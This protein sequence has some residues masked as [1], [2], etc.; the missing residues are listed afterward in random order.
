MIRGE[1]HGAALWYALPRS[2]R[3][4]LQVAFRVSLLDLLARTD[5]RLLETIPTGLVSRVVETLFRAFVAGYDELTSD[6]ET[7]D[8]ED[9]IAS[10]LLVRDGIEEQRNS[11][12]WAAAENRL[13]RELMDGFSLSDGCIDWEKLVRFVVENQQ[14]DKRGQNC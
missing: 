13:A 2:L 8:A 9:E 14:A 1:A 6:Q 12:D 3:E 10:I 11:I 4:R 7:A 5:P